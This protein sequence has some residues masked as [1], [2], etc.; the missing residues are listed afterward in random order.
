M[1]DFENI[2]NDAAVKEYQSTT[3]VFG[4]L[5][6]EVRELSK[7]KPDA[8]LSAS[9]VKLINNVLAD[10]L[11]FLSGEPEGKYLKSLEDDELPQTSDAL[12]MM[13]QF[14]A[15]LDAFKARY[16]QYVRKGHHRGNHHWIT[17]ETVER[18][19]AEVAELE[20]EDGDDEF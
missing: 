13:A 1:T 4:A 20:A 16:Y 3:G 17:E 14:D 2:T 10:L 6:R 15:A 12:L 11:T 18:W 8:T 9:K 7:K 19:A 5:L